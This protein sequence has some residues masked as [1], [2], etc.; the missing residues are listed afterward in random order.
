ML[1][2][3]RKIQFSF[4]FFKQKRRNILKGTK[5]VPPIH[6]NFYKSMS[7]SII[8]HKSSRVSEL[9]PKKIEPK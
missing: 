4:F 9:C 7:I 5:G 8:T 6:K 2:N 1:A 3:V